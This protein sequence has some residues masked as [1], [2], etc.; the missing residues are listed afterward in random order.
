MKWILRERIVNTFVHK[1]FLP[2]LCTLALLGV[3]PL[4]SASSLES[5]I[6]DQISKGSGTVNLNSVLGDYISKIKQYAP[7]KMIDFLNTLMLKKA[8]VVNGVSP[9]KENGFTV[10]GIIDF[11][12]TADVPINVYVINDKNIVLELLLSK[13]FTF[14]NIDPSIKGL[15]SIQVGGLRLIYT[16]YNYLDPVSSVEVSYV[17]L[18]FLS[19]VSIDSPFMRDIKA[20]VSKLGASVKA[21]SLDR[22]NGGIFIPPTIKGSTFRLLFPLGIDVNFEQLYAQGKT[23]YPPAVIKSITLDNTVLSVS[24]F[25]LEIGLE[26]TIAI[27]LVSQTEELSFTLGGTVNPTKAGLYGEMVGMYSP[28]F[29][30]KWLG[31]GNLALGLDW[32]YE[33]LPA[34][35]AVGIPFTGLLLGGTFVLGSGPD[36]ATIKVATQAAVSVTA[37]MQGGQPSTFGPQ[38]GISG[39]VDQL[40]FTAILDLLRK[41]IIAAG[42]SPAK[43]GGENMP[44]IKFTNVELTIA[45]TKIVLP[46]PLPKVSEGVRIKGNMDL[47]GLKGFLNIECSPTRL[48][49]D[50][51]GSLDPIVTKVFSLT[52]MEGNNTPASFDIGVSYNEAPHASIDA[53]FSIPFIGLN[54]GLKFS[55]DVKGLFAKAV[56]GLGAFQAAG[57]VQIPFTNF[58]DLVIDFTLDSSLPDMVS[59]LN[60]NIHDELQKWATT[61]ENAFNKKAGDLI[62]QINALQKSIDQKRDAAAYYKKE[63]KEN[64]IFSQRGFEGCVTGLT[65]SLDADI[66]AL[67]QKILKLG[68]EVIEDAKE[69]PMALFKAAD[70]FVD[71][72]TLVQI[73]KITGKLTGVQIKALQLPTITVTLSFNWGG[74]QQIKTLT[75]QGFNLKDPVAS[76]KQIVDEI[77]TFIFSLGKGYPRGIDPSN[78]ASGRE[79]PQLPPGLTA[80]QIGNGLDFGGSG[81]S[82]Y[83]ISYEGVQIVNPPADYN[84]LFLS[85][86]PPAVR[87]PSAIYSVAFLQRDGMPANSSC[88]IYFTIDTPVGKIQLLVKWSPTDNWIALKSLYDSSVDTGW[89]QLTI[90]DVGQNFRTATFIDKDKNRQLSVLYGMADS[91]IMLLFQDITDVPQE[92]SLQFSSYRPSI[93]GSGR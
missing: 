68:K 76:T 31:L 73:S 52:G 48:I 77:V 33:V 14:S 44:P 21:D 6:R 83:T 36:K 63:C 9:F 12:G 39:T 41:M 74:G 49:L 46:T 51:K 82:S 19:Y 23:K 84:V 25:N 66:D 67:H 58:D 17:G 54:Q 81:R 56:L 53:L 79:S 62:K 47:A 22:L 34:T 92:S 3:T 57:S 61:V 1:Y 4:R 80:F 7:T 86:A 30:Q 71:V 69:V 38:F 65:K 60:R 78:P 26:G 10:T 37:A 11:F 15:D 2:F 28:A 20:F 85:Y 32:E 13:N 70:A 72:A 24:P 55:L 35:L 93:W 59:K 91:T 45:P 40:N 43:V 16:T 64:S 50:G 5:T 87:I 75:I 18:N 88:D 42:A 90:K 89:A 8:T 27:K 29:G